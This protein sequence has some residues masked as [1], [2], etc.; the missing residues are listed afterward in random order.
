MMLTYTAGGLAY[1]AIATPGEDLRPRFTNT[2]SEI[3]M[4]SPLIFFFFLV[5]QSEKLKSSYYSTSIDIFA[6]EM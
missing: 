4:E 2:N 6:R 5:D 3:N 1:T